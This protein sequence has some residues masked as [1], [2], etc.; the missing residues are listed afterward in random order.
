MDMQKL[1]DTLNETSSRER[2][3][4]HLTYGD[5]VK[6]LKSADKKAT[7]DKRI[8]GIGSYRGYYT[9]IALFTDE[10]G[11]YAEDE[12]FTGDWK[13]HDEWIKEHSVTVEK[14]PTNA[15]ELGELLE[16]LIGKDFIGYKG[17]NF[18][19]FENK[20]LWFEKEYSNSSGNAVIG[21]DEE[22]NLITKKLNNEER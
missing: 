13:E 16:S 17:G 12:E 2:G 20:P 10:V 18:T 4:Y 22:L 19:I 11:L 7:F 5:L 14:L 15:N 6:A 1:V 8:K 21:I 3:N 9:D